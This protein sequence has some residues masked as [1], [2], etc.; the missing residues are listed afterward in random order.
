MPVDLTEEADYKLRYAAE[1]ARIIGTFE[2]CIE[3]ADAAWDAR[4]I[5]GSDLDAEEDA[6]TEV[7]YWRELF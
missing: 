3:S 1:M 4:E 2:G 6:R 7:A 5:N